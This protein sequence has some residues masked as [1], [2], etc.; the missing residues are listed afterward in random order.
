VAF[1]FAMSGFFLAFI[2]DW[3]PKLSFFL[4]FTSAVAFALP[5]TFDNAGWIAV[6][7]IYLGLALAYWVLP[8]MMVQF[9]PERKTK[10]QAHPG[11]RKKRS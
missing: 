8:Q 1:F 7:A 9:S 4:G 5:A 6:A 11:E 3:Q 2:Y 10:P